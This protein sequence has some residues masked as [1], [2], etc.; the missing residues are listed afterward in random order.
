M[1][2]KKKK[3]GF[4]SDPSNWRP[5]YLTVYDAKKQKTNK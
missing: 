1:K 4:K 5:I 3:T 2:K